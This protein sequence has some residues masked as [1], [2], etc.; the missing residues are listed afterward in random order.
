M[1]KRSCLNCTKKN[2]GVV[3]RTRNSTHSAERQATASNPG[4]FVVPG[5]AVAGA[6]AGAGDVAG[7]DTAGP[8][9]PGWPGAG[10]T[11]VVAAVIVAG[12]LTYR[13][14]VAGPREPPSPTV[15]VMAIGTD[16][17]ACAGVIR[18]I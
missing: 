8:A 13:N 14:R 15:L 18:V 12:A 16:P 11:V 3:F 5:A 1:D 4:A 7:K 17:G 9:S 6:A 10:V 2:Q